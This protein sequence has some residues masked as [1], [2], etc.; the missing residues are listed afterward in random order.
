MKRFGEQ[1]CDIH[2]GSPRQQIAI[3]NTIFEKE[4]Y[5]KENTNCNS[6]KQEKDVGGK[7]ECVIDPHG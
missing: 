6:H 2:Q 7:G 1:K 5:Q 3:R 4:F